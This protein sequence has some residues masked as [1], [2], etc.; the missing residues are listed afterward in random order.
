MGRTRE[1]DVGEAADAARDAFW[2]RGYA[3]T[4]VDGLRAATGVSVGSLYKAFGGKAALHREGL[5]RYLSGAREQT[6]RVLADEDPVRGLETW[7]SSAVDGT[8]TP[9]PTGGCFAV[10]TAAELAAGEVDVAD[11]VREH[12]EV[13][14]AVVADAVRRA[15]PR[16]G[17]APERAARLL[18]TVVKGLQVT[19]RAGV[20]REDAEAV[21]DAALRGVLDDRGG[22]R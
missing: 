1:F 13:L 15:G 5:R 20:G 10:Q 11:L 8:C 4:S 17:L 12:D 16:D 19:A 21:V 3:A 18:L 9:G 2:A 6:T 7:L 22:R 14:L